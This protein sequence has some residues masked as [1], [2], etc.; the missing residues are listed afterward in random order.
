MH[1]GTHVDAPYHFIADGKT[2]EQLA[3]DVLV[4][5]AQV[6]ELPEDCRLIGAAEL[7]SR[8]GSRREWSACC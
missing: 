5:P 1:I 7:E 8:P 2:I 4:G 3:L 6:V